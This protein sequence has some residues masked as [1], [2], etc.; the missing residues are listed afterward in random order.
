MKTFD[1]FEAETSKIITS[2]QEIK[3]LQLKSG[4]SKASSVIK[5]AIASKGSKIAAMIENDKVVGAISYFHDQDKITT[6]EY[7]GSVKPK[8]GTAL[9]N[10]VESESKSK[11]QKKL[12]VWSYETAD[13]FYLHLGFRKGTS[14]EGHFEK[15]IT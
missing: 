3:A 10:F 7:V 12:T 9:I 14:G 4:S 13:S 2:R 11:G 5:Q 6:I 8:I 15:L 1:L